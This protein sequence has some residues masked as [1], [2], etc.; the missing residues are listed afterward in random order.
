MGRPHTGLGKGAGERGK[1]V[2][3]AG[4]CEGGRLVSGVA[5]RWGT[6][7][8]NEVELGISQTLSVRF[9]QW[10]LGVNRPNARSNALVPLRL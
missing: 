2:G 9:V 7:L 10:H 1:V 4:R 6:T 8:S 5:E 3:E